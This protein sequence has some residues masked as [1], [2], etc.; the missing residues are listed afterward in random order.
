M[1]FDG[2][3]RLVPVRGW[4]NV[5]AK[6]VSHS[7]FQVLIRKVKGWMGGE[8]TTCWDCANSVCLVLRMSLNLGYWMCCLNLLDAET[9]TAKPIQNVKIVTKWE[10]IWLKKHYLYA[11]I[12][13]FILKILHYSA[14]H[15]HDSVH[16]KVPFCLFSSVMSCCC[17]SWRCNCQLW[18]WLLLL[19]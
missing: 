1:W 12:I 9:T 8:C 18:W 14:S 6:F 7:V 5:K 11:F 4:R 19:L 13:S 10:S 15:S 2:W 3:F 16:F 17:C